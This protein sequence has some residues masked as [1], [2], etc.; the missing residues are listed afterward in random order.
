MNLIYCPYKNLLN[1]ECKT[2]NKGQNIRDLNLYYESNGYKFPLLATRVK[3]CTFEVLN[4]VKTNIKT[5]APNFNYYLR[6]INVDD[7]DIKKTIS[8]FRTL[9]FNDDNKIYTNRFMKHG[10]Y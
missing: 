3:N 5:F 7:E 8:E 6:L 2:C 10:V 4:S 1:I 9:N